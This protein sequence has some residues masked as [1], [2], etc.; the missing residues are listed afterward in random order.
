MPTVTI[1]VQHVFG[2][3]LQELSTLHQTTHMNIYSF[4]VLAHYWNLGDNISTVLRGPF[5]CTLYF[6]QMSGLDLI[7]QVR[8]A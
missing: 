3:C 5:V 6:R 1:E 8:S 2:Q 7:S 4:L